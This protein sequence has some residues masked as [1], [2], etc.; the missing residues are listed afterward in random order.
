MDLNLADLLTKM[1]SIA[2]GLTL[3]W[4]AYDAWKA[5][6]ERLFVTTLRHDADRLDLT[7]D[8][9][10]S[11]DHSGLEF[12]IT[13]QAPASAVVSAYTPFLDGFD[14]EYARVI[15]DPPPGAARRVRCASAK[16]PEEAGG[17]Y[18]VHAEV[19]R[20][21]GISRA[22]VLVRVEQRATGRTLLT[23]VYDVSATD[24]R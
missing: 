4:R 11:S 20:S 13:V 2:G 14:L 12:E 15:G 23:R 19:H 24:D 22:R 1:G 21:G 5:H 7:I 3:A 17:V 18:R 10:S 16:L 8:Y 9:T 6:Q